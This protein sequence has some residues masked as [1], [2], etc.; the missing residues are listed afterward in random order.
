MRAKRTIGLALTIAS[1][2]I[3]LYAVIHY[4]L[5]SLPSDKC[6]KCWISSLGEQ[7]IVRALDDVRSPEV[8]TSI[9][10]DYRGLD[11]LFETSVFFLAIIGI[12][13]LFRGFEEK[14]RNGGKS[15]EEPGMSM[16]VKTV[17]RI[18]VVLIIV[19]SAS[20]AL[21]GQLTPGGGFQGGAALAVAPLLAIVA[22]GYR[23]LEEKGIRET[24]ILGLRSVA[25][26]I[27]AVVALSPLL[28]AYLYNEQMYIM[29]NQAKPWA[30]ISLLPGYLGNTV[31]GGTLLVFNVA[32]FIAVGAAFTAI[33]LV[34]SIPETKVM[35]ILR[36]EENEH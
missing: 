13:A 10:W 27:I 22:F 24:L 26:T 35:E 31:L 33:F 7:Y 9:V 25:V 29:Q 15:S 17:T 1:V 2:L 32:E 19:V 6:V 20:I 3:T 14:N 23:S 30:P 4:D 12:V 11:T 34:L 5:F 36:G 28:V 16:I 21:H 18:I 8:V